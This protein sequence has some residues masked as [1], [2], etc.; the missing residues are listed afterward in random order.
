MEISYLGRRPSYSPEGRVHVAFGPQKLFCPT[1]KTTPAGRQ[2]AVVPRTARQGEIIH[3]HDPEETPFR[4]K[5]ILGSRDFTMNPDE[6][7][8]GVEIA[9][10]LPPHGTQ[11]I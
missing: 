3:R 8:S 7:K 9:E 4:P 1:A 11:E 5:Y 6:S 2:K 10:P